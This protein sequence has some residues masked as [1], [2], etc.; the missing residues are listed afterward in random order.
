[1]PLPACDRPADGD[2]GDL[3]A[4]LRILVVEDNP[5][6]QQLARSQ[7]DR[8]GLVPVIVGTGEE[9]MA[10]LLDGSEH[11]DV[12]LMD[13][14]LPGWSGT[15]TTRRIRELDGALGAVPII[16]LSA[17]ASRA[18]FDAFM[19]AGMDDFVPKPASLGDLS[20]A[21]GAAVRRGGRTTGGGGAGQRSSAGST[22][23][24]VGTDPAGTPAEQLLDVGVL[25]TLAE[26]LGGTG[27]VIDL[28]DVFLRELD[29]RIA[30]L[31]AADSGEARRTAHTL[32]SSARLLGAAAL[33]DVCA[34]IEQ[35]AA[36]PPDLTDLADRSRRALG[37]WLD[38]QAT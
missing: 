17:S 13:Q 2:H 28:V 10:A 35:G 20:S 3:L 12:V 33:A 15:E 23:D 26:E 25:A 27:I 18:D 6:N 7:L 9:G 5:V 24:T 14:Q 22:E 32:K 37:V 16:G 11:F 30:V 31:V 29:G 34:E 19:T 21:I 8:L 36:A 1:L 4:G 38:A